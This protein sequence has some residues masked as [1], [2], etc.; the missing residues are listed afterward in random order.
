MY[1]FSAVIT[2]TWNNED[3]TI[4]CFG[5]IQ[6]NTKDYKIIWIDNGSKKES[7]EKV[8]RFLDENSVPY[9]LIQNEE[10]LGFIK[11]TNQGMKRAMELEA[12][13]VI[14]Q[15]NDTEIYEGW[16][17]RMIEVAESD[18]NIGLVGPI[19]SPCTTPQS[20]EN[21]KNDRINFFDLPLYKNNPEEYAGIIKKKYKDQSIELKVQVAFF[22]TLIKKKLIDELGFLSEEFGVGFGDDDDYCIR[23]MKNGWKIFL[24]KDVFV[25]HNH[26]TTFKSIYSDEKIESM[27]LDNAAIFKKKHENFFSKCGTGKAVVL[28]SEESSKVKALRDELRR[29]VNSKSF[30][31]GNLFFRSIRKPIKLVTFPINFIRIL[32]SKKR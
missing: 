8:K 15:N 31:L 30:L 21:L 4:R 22:S 26:R 16:L 18:E 20:I 11:A 24:A 28:S 27:L 1:K 3:Y 32:I 29:V 19:T 25:F 2:P 5:S 7:R 14:L 13:Y 12:E 17:E 9:E 10:N 23:A 6:K